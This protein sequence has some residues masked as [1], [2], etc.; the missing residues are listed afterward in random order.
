LGAKN[1]IYDERNTDDRFGV[2][3]DAGEESSEE[4]LNKMTEQFKQ[5]GAMEI[6]ILD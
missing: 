1:K 4:I 6:K 2:V 5:T 3:L